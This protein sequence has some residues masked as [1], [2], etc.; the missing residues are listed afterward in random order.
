[1]E[2]PEKNSERTYVFLPPNKLAELKRIAKDKGTTAS[3]FI[4]MIVLE[5]L[6]KK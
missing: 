2:K 3:G 6:A 1:M 5:Y 4:R